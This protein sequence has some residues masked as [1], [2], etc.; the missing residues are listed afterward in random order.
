MPYVAGV[1]AQDGTLLMPTANP[2]KVRRLLKSGRAHICNHDPFV[3]QLDYETAEPAHVQPI[4]ISFDAGYRH[5]GLSVKSEKHEYVSAEYELLPDEKE[6]HDARRKCRRERRNRLRHRKPRF[7]NRRRPEGW[8]TPSLRNKADAQVRLVEKHA[9]AYPVSAIYFEGGQFDTQVLV[10]MEAGEPV[11]EGEGYQH[12]PRY[13]YETLRE[14]VFARDDYKCVCC[15]ASGIPAP[16]RPGVP[17]RVHH[18]GYLKHDHSDRMANLAT[19]CANCHTPANHQPGGKLYG[20]KPKLEPFRGAAF[21]NTVK[22]RMCETLRKEYPSVVH[23]T[24]GAVTKL[25]RAGRN[26]A[27]S[28]VNDAY[29]IGEFRPRHRA[30]TQHFRKTRRHNRVLSKFYDAKYVDSRDGGVKKGAQLSGGRARRSRNG[31]EENLRRYRQNK[32][33]KGRVVLRAASGKYHHGDVVL[34]K[35]RRYAVSGMGGGQ[36]KVMIIRKDEKREPSVNSVKLLH[37]SNGWLPIM[38]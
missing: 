9:G 8:L 16:N 24:Y 3:I 22:W 19:V 25:A 21:M 2:R 38:G 15:G 36:T 30:R 1:M 23:L 11:P 20:F 35:G 26:I 28:H 13:G 5:V 17:L 4:E 10:A 6:R 14:A 18:L 34:Y 31:G 32:V 27:K 12:G 33:Q 37:R 7:G 29:C